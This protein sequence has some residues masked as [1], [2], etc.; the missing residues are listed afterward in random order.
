MISSSQATN[1]QIICNARAALQDA[2]VAKQYMSQNKDFQRQ[3]KEWTQSYAVK[4]SANDP[5]VSRCMHHTD[6]LA[7]SVPG[8]MFHL[9]LYWCPHLLPCDPQIAFVRVNALCSL[10]FPPGSIQYAHSTLSERHFCFSRCSN[11]LIWAFHMTLFPEHCWLLGV[12]KMQLLNGFWV[13]ATS[14][15]VESQKPCVAKHA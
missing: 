10:Q 14:H 13:D 4:P 5:R 2:V 6:S 3:A 11:W 12:T 8:Q 7:I 9:A 1:L 15:S